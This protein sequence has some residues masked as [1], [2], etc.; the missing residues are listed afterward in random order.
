MEV[1]RILRLR[2]VIELTGFKRSSIYEMMNQSRFP[3]S[4]RIGLRAVGWD[5]VEVNEWVNSKLGV[6]V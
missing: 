5:S 4:R 3:K 6:G 1:R 2:H